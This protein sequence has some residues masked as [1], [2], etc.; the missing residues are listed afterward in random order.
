VYA[1][2]PRTTSFAHKYVRTRG[3]RRY[4]P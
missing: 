1:R 4:L 2:R 3:D